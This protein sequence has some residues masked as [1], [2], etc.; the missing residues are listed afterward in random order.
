MNV[1]YELELLLYKYNLKKIYNKL[2]IEEYNEQK[3]VKKITDI[4]NDK[5]IAIWCAGT[6]TE[7]LLSIIGKLCKNIVCI[8]DNNSA[9][10][11]NEINGIKI[12][13]KKDI[14]KYNIDIIVI[15]TMSYIKE[16][17]VE[18]ESLGYSYILFYSDKNYIDINDEYA[19]KNSK[20]SKSSLDYLTFEEINIDLFLLRKAYENEYIKKNKEKLLKRLI[21]EYFNIRDFVYGKRFV[22]EYIKQKYEDFERLE[23]F[24]EELDD[25]FEKI[26]NIIKNR[27]YRDVILTFFDALRF[28][29]IDKVKKG[30]INFK[31]FNKIANNSVYYTNVISNSTY[32]RASFK[33][34]FYGKDNMGEKLFTNKEYSINIDESEVLKLIIKEG[35]KIVNNALVKI[36]GDYEENIVNLMSS[37][38]YGKES[39]TYQLWQNICFLCSEKRPLLLINHFFESHPPYSSGYNSTMGLVYSTTIKNDRMKYY[40]QHLESIDY[41]EKQVQFY[42]NLFSENSFKIITSDHGQTQFEVNEDEYNMFKPCDYNI[43]TPL[44]IQHK[45][46]KSQIR[47]ELFSKSDLFWIILSLIKKNEIPNIKRE[48]V[49]IQRDRMY[50]LNAL[51]KDYGEKNKKY[52]MSFECIQTLNEK[53]VIYNKDIEELYILPNE[54]VNR[55]NDYSLKNTIKKLK[56][57]L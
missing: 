26:S 8:I 16:I 11:G 2:Y 17:S 49:K 23:L 14:E 48:F 51:P 32:T 37:K 5:R 22:L 38:E 34:M 7:Y 44:C 56:E 33:A 46:L 42:Y 13:G 10:W 36:E 39:C 24:L 12:V 15:S 53:Y 28:D 55:I 20:V 40:N 47:N 45:N 57:Y 43:K 1:E 9:L 4:S 52:T 50:N 18:V 25:L 29:L 3:I 30:K 19:I 21:I 6:H 27:P 35:Y 31:I 54:S 41:L